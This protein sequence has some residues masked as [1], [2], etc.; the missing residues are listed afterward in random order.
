MPPRLAARWLAELAEAVQH[1]HDRGILHR[2]IK[3]DNVIL[4]S[5]DALSAAIPTREP[6][7]TVSPGDDPSLSGDLNPERFVPRLT[8]FGLAKLFKEP[9]DE[10][11]SGARMGTPNYMAPEQAAGRKKEVGPA[12]DVYALGATLY[13]VLTGRPP[14]RG[15]TDMETLRLVVET[16]PVALRALRPGLPRD[17]DTICQKCLRKEPAGRY[18][19]A[20]ALADDLRRL[21]DGRPIVGRPVSSWERAWRWGRRRPAV[22]A[23]VGLVVLLAG[24]LIGGASRWNAQLLRHNAQLKEQIALADQQARIAEDAGIKPTATTTRK[25][26]GWLAGHSSPDRSSWRRI[27]STR[28]KQGPMVSTHGASPGA[29]SGERP[30]AS[31]RSF[32]DMTRLFRVRSSPLTERLSRLRTCE[33]R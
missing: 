17:L 22:A 28:F 12:T 1:A 26:S 16:E 18:A 13:E 29:I 3:P 20:A 15:E 8:D 31:S 10:T 5:R 6:A 33:A 32:G 27:S 2:D 14:F 25:I 19:S 21:L 11:K 7:T 24:V 23:L 9:V 30:I 4:A